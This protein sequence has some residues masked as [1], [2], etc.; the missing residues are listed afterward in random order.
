MQ[1]K[2]R[3]GLK[4]RHQPSYKVRTAGGPVKYLVTNLLY[5]IIVNNKK[6]TVVRGKWNNISVIF[7]D[8]LK[9]PGLRN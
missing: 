2:A 3:A 7:K 6:D 5:N 9:P 8:P 4:P 1:Q